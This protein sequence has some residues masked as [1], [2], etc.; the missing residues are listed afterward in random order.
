MYH[1]VGGVKAEKPQALKL[2]SEKALVIAKLKVSLT[3]AASKHKSIHTLI[4]SYQAFIGD[5]V[6]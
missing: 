6:R 5:H 1:Q 2:G 3:V 4:R